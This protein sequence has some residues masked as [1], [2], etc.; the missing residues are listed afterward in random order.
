VTVLALDVDDDASVADVFGKVG[1]SLDVL[2]NN[3]GIYSIDAV[4]TSPAI[5][6]CGSRS[7]PTRCSQRPAA[8]RGLLRASP[9]ADR[10][11]SA[12]DGA[13]NRESAM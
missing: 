7:V 11:R 4:A 9:R 1:S 13:L 2:V 6:G 5:R 12:F 10:S 8:R 3:A